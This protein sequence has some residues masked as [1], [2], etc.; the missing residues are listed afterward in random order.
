MKSSPRPRDQ[1]FS[2]YAE[3]SCINGGQELQKRCHLDFEGRFE[4]EHPKTPITDISYK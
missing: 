2:S 3:N 4:L 1:L